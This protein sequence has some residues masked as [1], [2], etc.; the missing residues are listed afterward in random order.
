ML[1]VDAEYASRHYNNIK[2]LSKNEKFSDTSAFLRNIDYMPDRHL[3]RDLLESLTDNDYIR[4][5]LNVILIVTTGSGKIFIANALGG[6]ACQ[7]GYK[8]RHIRLPELFSKLETAR[9]QGKYHQVMKQV[10]KLPL[11]IL[12]EFLLISASNPEQRDLLELMEYRC[13][14]ISTIFCSQFRPEGCHER[15]GG[16][17]LV[18]S[19][20]DR[21][22]PSAYTMR[23]DVDVSMR[24]RKRVI[25]N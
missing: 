2:R 3:N 24:Q 18:D 11:V 20:L 4:Q 22:I 19:I 15:L 14:Q 7:S 21:S 8:T 13:V 25:K 17:D 16:S 10:Q 23:I 6:K 9:I 5:E 12:D 1:F